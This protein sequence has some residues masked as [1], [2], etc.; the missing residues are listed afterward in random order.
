MATCW[1]MTV[2]SNAHVRATG[3]AMEQL[4]SIWTGLVRRVSEAAAG[5]ATDTNRIEERTMRFIVMVVACVD[6][7]TN[8]AMDWPLDIRAP[9]FEYR[10]P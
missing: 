9:F 6:K 10:G 7:R 2:T 5:A 8:R 1:K 4:L 3:P